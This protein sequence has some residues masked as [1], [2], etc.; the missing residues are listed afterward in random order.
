MSMKRFKIG[1]GGIALAAAAYFLIFSAVRY[2]LSAASAFMERQENCIV[3]DAGHGGEDGGATGAAGSSESQINLEISLRLEQLLRFC[4]YET[5]LIRSTDT[6]VYTGDCHTITEKKVSD[7]KNRVEIVNQLQ[8][9]VLVSIHQ[10][11]FSEEKYSGSQ[12]FYAKTDTSR[13]LAEQ[14]QEA[15]RNALD[16]KNHRQCKQADSVYLMEHITCPGV[17]VECGFLSN[18]QEEQRLQQ[19]DYQKKLVCAITGALAQYLQKGDS[20]HEV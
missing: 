14:M 10:N 2:N 4:G 20:R 15:L 19:P 6:A 13:E 18:R 17:L 9:A 3:I 7:L 1:V 8:P 16:A 12:V 5:Y 11:H